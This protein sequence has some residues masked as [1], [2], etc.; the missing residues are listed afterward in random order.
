MSLLEYAIREDLNKI[1][2]RVM[3]VLDPVK[4][5]IT[6]YPED[7]KELLEGEINP[8]MLELGKRII[9]FR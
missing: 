6:N 7:Q 9:P 2:P 8:E 3:G 4:L 5:T 1:A